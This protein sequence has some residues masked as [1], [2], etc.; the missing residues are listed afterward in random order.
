MGCGDVAG[1]ARGRGRGKATG[2]SPIKQSLRPLPPP[3]PRILLVCLQTLYGFPRTVHLSEASKL[4]ASRRVIYC[5]H[6]FLPSPPSLSAPLIPSQR[7]LTRQIYLH[8]AEHRNTLHYHFFISLY[9]I[10]L[11]TFLTPSEYLFLPLSLLSLPPP[12][13]SLSYSKGRKGDKIR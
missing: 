11:T 2:F 13:G 8:T 6:T 10:F 7:K 9:P 5:S 1:D 4:K 3:Q 12:L